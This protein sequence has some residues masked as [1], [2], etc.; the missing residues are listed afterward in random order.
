MMAHGS[1][2]ALLAVRPDG[3]LMADLRDSLMDSQVDDLLNGLMDAREINL[4]P[5]RTSLGLRFR[6]QSPASTGLQGC[7]DGRSIVDGSS[8]QDRGVGQG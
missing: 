6:L 8:G 7:R 3:W 1:P 4:H 5:C 2:D